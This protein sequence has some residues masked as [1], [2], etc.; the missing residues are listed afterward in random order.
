MSLDEAGIT[1]RRFDCEAG[2]HEPFETR[3]VWN[4]RVEPVHMSIETDRHGPAHFAVCKH[5]RVLYLR[6]ASE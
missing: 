2:K 5:C 4:G 1:E 6:K 3:N